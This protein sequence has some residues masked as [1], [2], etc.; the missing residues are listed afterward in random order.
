[1][2][3][4]HAARRVTADFLKYQLTAFPF[5]DPRL[6]RQLRELLKVDDPLASPLMKG[7]YLSLSRAFRPGP[8]LEHLASEGV[9]HPHLSNLFPIP[10]VHGHQEKAIRAI[11]NMQPTVVSTGTGSGKTE[12]FLIPIISHCLKLRD[13]GDA[14]GIRAVIVY[15][16]NALAED[17]L[18][19]LR[20]LL[21]GTGVP[22][23]MYVGKTPERESD[24]TG[25]RSAPSLADYQAKVQMLRDTEQNLPVLPPEE[26]ASRE[27]LR[28]PGKQPR[29]LLTN[30][31][32]LEL[33]LTRSTDVELFDGA[34]LDFMV[35]DEAH[36][37][38]G[39]EGA[40]AAV[41]MRR[42]RS[43]CGQKPE[44]TI[45][46]A[47]S[48]TL[49]D[50]FDPTPA[51]TYMSRFFGV[52]ADQ[53]AVVNEDYEDED[54]KP[55]RS[56]IASM[57]EAVASERL[58]LCINALDSDE[59]TA[60]TIVSG[61]YRQITGRSLS[62]GDWR[63]SLFE[64]LT[65][66]ENAYQIAQLLK[67]P[68]ALDEVCHELG[69]SPF[70][71]LLWLTLG[72]AAKR[73]G[74][75]LL[76]PV[77]HGFVRGI[78]GAVVG[79]PEGT[80][81]K[82]WLSTHDAE[83]EAPGIARLPVATCNNCGL[84]YYPLFVRDYSFAGTSPSGGDAH[85][86]GTCWPPLDEAQAGCR[87]ILTDPLLNSE[88]DD[89]HGS[90]DVR[91]PNGAA[92]VDFCRECGAICSGLASCGNCGCSDL[93]P[94]LAVQ[95]DGDDQPARMKKCISCS[96]GQ[97]RVF[98]QAREPARPVR[99]TVVSD[100]H[101]LSQNLLQ[102]ANSGTKRLLVFADSRQDAA[103]Q[104]GWMRD[105]ARR[106]RIRALVDEAV[107]AS[108][109]PTGLDDLVNALGKNF[110]TD[111]KLSQALLPEVWEIAEPTVAN[112][113][114]EQ[115]RKDYLKLF[116]M[117]ELAMGWRQKAGLE[118]WGRIRVKYVGLDA[119]RP[120]FSKWS[121]ALGLPPEELLEGV[122]GI[123][124]LYRRR[125]CLFDDQ[126][127]VFTTHLGDGHKWIQRL[128]I[129]QIDGAPAAIA[130]L[131]PR[132]QTRLQGITGP[133]KQS[134]GDR[135]A[136]L[137]NVPESDRDGFL[138]ELWKELTDRKILRAVEVQYDNGNRAKGFD[139][140]FQIDAGT[141]ALQA[142]EGVF[143]CNTCRKAFCRPLPSGRCLH[144]R[145]GGSVVWEPEDNENYD[146]MTLREGYEMVR[147]REHSAQVPGPE[148]EKLEIAFKSGAEEV[149]TLVCTPTLEM[150]VDIG[151]L[152]FVLLRN[153]PPLP[154]NY[155][156]RVGR[157]GR[158]ERIALNLSYARPTRH[159]RAYF[160]DPIRMLRGKV[161]PPRFNLRNPVMLGKHIRSIV[162]ASL[163]RLTRASSGLTEQDRQDITTALLECFPSQI[164]SMLFADDGAILNSPRSVQTISDQVARYRERLLDES[165]EVFIKGWPEDASAL[166]TRVQMEL[167]L[168]QFGEELGSVY[169]R[170]FRRLKWAQGQLTRLGSLKATKGALDEEDAALEKRCLMVVKR[171]K[172]DQNRGRAE[173]E[174]IDDSL[175][176]SVLA[177]EGF[178]P[179]Y[180]LTGGGIRGFAEP[181][182]AAN[183]VLGRT[184]AVG[185]RE[186]IPGNLLYANNRRFYTSHF[187]FGTGDEL[188][189]R[190]FIV[191]PAR[192]LLVE[193]AGGTGMGAQRMEFIPACDVSLAQR[194]L[195]SDEEDTRFMMPVTVLIREEGVYGE[196]QAYQW[197]SRSL[198]W[199]PQVY[200]LAANVG[201]AR[202]VQRGVMGYLTC[203]VCGQARSP[204]ASQAEVAKFL[205]SHS[206]RCGTA[207]KRLGVYAR[208]VADCV[209]LQGCSRVGAYSV[210]EA[211]RIGASRVLEME[212]EDVHLATVPVEG[213]DDTVDL[214]LIDPMPGGS[215][216]LQQMIEAWPL[217]VEAA[218]EVVRN[219]PADCGSSCADCL[220]TYR[221]QQ[222]HSN[223]DRAVASSLL[224]SLGLTLSVANLIP[225]KI[226]AKQT[227]GDS[228][229]PGEQRLSELLTRAG[230]QPDH[231]QHTIG[232]PDISSHTVP[233]VYF[234]CETEAF[235]GVC[236]YLDGLSK[237]LHGDPGTAARDQLL[238]VTLEAGG[239]KV[240]VIPA[241]EL[242]DQ[243]A[244]VNHFV[245]IARAI[246]GKAHASE[247]QASADHWWKPS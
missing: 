129:P 122:C 26:V 223:L 58:D 11:A 83:A 109:H 126:T 225:A 177:A 6:Y 168:D 90:N 95:M 54:W 40:E 52:E 231:V 86:E 112:Q 181:Y 77:V 176:F 185:I 244:M 87:A 143:R 2:N 236:V 243:N 138:K 27:M 149:N 78:D 156:Q 200:L 34:R 131:K 216:L 155:W 218:L 63:A 97:R 211:L 239:Y 60:G 212:T 32:M 56:L 246:K 113:V 217:V 41:L 221:N 167:V 100:V 118:P 47:T 210:G 38:R 162:L 240:I 174:G 207:P 31:K 105:H 227:T 28:T 44:E 18:G 234:E 67:A 72:A 128:F 75:R 232:L 62:S 202:L 134:L 17:Q 57:T 201:E 94:M 152:D 20:E 39:A 93:V 132:G 206:K 92:A 108:S 80:D 208:T 71:V 172:G 65:G 66:I 145:C 151:A 166:V 35:V 144:H 59:A 188:P 148:R 21:V 5:S 229:N 247:V 196:G 189:E 245:A 159:D 51:Q 124:D 153:I 45:S 110:S 64:E 36:T 199:R 219:C 184:S 30:V 117:R 215:G 85:G 43:Y 98:G 163:H 101:V 61:V 107:R 133:T 103:F 130:F 69:I 48:A 49:A 7:P 191:D 74:R 170:V 91:V 79:Y 82:L 179:G 14:P 4:I 13:E 25:L 22:F 96:S 220:Q 237:G 29:I 137:W 186:F 197:G 10:N 46:I 224:E 187:Q 171:L 136:R 141:I 180:G 165:A 89:D 204:Y 8:S 175:T 127:R 116:L 158:R 106:Y 161:D 3:P 114:H 147:P 19:R 164:R 157:A 73:G 140:A 192:Q 104:A 146:L 242:A 53:V 228:T 238:R 84:H 213:Q 24:V 139:N 123:L 190:S 120:F 226:S 173:A 121:Q 70:E 125:Y 183:F 203:K 222:Y 142:Q 55:S 214:L 195:I 68:Q 230:L 198:D 76:R 194:S 16:M 160:E 102:H 9:V 42:L 99:A 150:G 119:T 111:R 154:A 241:S 37:F 115:E 33:L 12:C 182:R 193:Q 135:A 23:A 178:L 233:D 81:P 88:D 235:D 1:M 205:E 15:P 209:R 50:A 169:H